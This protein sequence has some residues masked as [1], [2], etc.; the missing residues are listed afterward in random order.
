MNKAALLIDYENVMISLNDQG[1]FYPVHRIVAG[2]VE[3]AQEKASLFDATLDSRASYQ[4]AGLPQHE[5]EALM[6]AGIEVV[7]ST[8]AK[9]AADTKLVF[10]AAEHLFAKG[11]TVFFVVSGDVDYV[12]LALAL[13]GRQAVCYL[14]PASSSRLREAVVR[15][16]RKDFV[17][18]L[19]NLTPNPNRHA[20]KQK[21]FLLCVQ[22]LVSE[23]RYLGGP[24]SGQE[25]L[26]SQGILD[27]A[28]VETLWTIA[29][30]DGCFPPPHP[31]VVDGCDYGK[32]M[33]LRY[34]KPEVLRVFRIVD[35]I[36]DTVWWR[37][38]E[39]TRADILAA[40]RDLP[41]DSR[42][43]HEVLELLVTCRYLSPVGDERYMLDSPDLR[44]G[45]L[46][47]AYRL[48]ALIWGQT[49]EREAQG[50]KGV[51]LSAMMR[52]WPR[53]VRPGGQMNDAEID[54]AKKQLQKLLK[55][56]EAC[57]A[58]VFHKENPPHFRVYWEHPASAT[59]RLS[60]ET[61][62][63]LVEELTADAAAVPEDRLVEE[64][65]TISKAHKGHVPLF[66]C[67][68]SECMFWLSVFAAG[69]HLTWR[70]HT[71]ALRHDSA[72]V[73]HCL[74]KKKKLSA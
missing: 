58:I 66:G 63:G 62:F 65:K 44:F 14:W 24:K 31:V 21:L 46:R 11:Y 28:E 5:A 47:T 37:R 25:M 6:H 10:E 13:E 3:R 36:L 45:T 27:A 59:V 56:G 70:N 55:Q 12:D 48:V 2:L 72:L 20:D 67:L 18:E 38:G 64:M 19:L 16:K 26:R 61:L 22:K 51:G 53:H 8:A 9:N 39:A 42:D 33:R 54:A 30:N 17:V 23:G 49:L 35:A 57:G 50:W 7:T 15:Y 29:G 32:R 52:E 1:Y 43:C 69:R 41:G 34:D 73:K 74:T 40:L 71:V 60:A 68:T 4:P